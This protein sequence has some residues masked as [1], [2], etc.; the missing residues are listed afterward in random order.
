MK[1]GH[2]DLRKKVEGLSSEDLDRMLGEEAHQYT[3]DAL[4]I[5]HAEAQRRSEAATA[6]DTEPKEDKETPPEAA[7]TSEGVGGCLGVLGLLVGLLGFVTL[8]VQLAGSYANRTHNI[9]FAVGMIVFGLAGI[10]GGRHLR[11]ALRRAAAAEF[12]GADP[13]AIAALREAQGAVN[14]A[15][16]KGNLFVWP[17]LVVLLLVRGPIGGLVFAAGVIGWFAYLLLVVRPLGREVKRLRARLS[18]GQQPDGGPREAQ[19]A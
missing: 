8:V 9:L 15:I 14:K 6:T 19:Q 7:R 5:A 2:D 16:N 10:Y 18:S 4:A 13:A 11:R 12:P 17:A 1:P 3:E